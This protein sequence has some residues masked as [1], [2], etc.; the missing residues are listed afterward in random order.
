VSFRVFRATSAGVVGLCILLGG[1]SALAAT[2]AARPRGVN[3]RTGRATPPFSELVKAARKNDR[4]ALERLA[5]RFGVARL[6]E[7]ARGA[8]GAVARA[9]LEAI[10]FARG[11]VL[12]AGTVADRLDAGDPLLA[13]AA[14]RALGALLDGDAPTELAEWEVPADVVARACGGLRALATRA[15]AAAAARLEALDALAAAQVTCPPSADLAALLRD[16]S[17]AVRRSA[18][19][20]LATLPAGE[21]R[22]AALGLG[23]ADPDPGVS[24]A[25]AAAVCRRVEPSR[26]RRASGDAL[27]EQATGAARALVAI[28]ATRPE[29][30]VEMLA[31]VAAAGTPADRALLEKLR[32]GAASPVRDRAVELLAVAAPGKPGAPE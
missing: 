4:A 16:P 24:A 17:P 20:L 6:G 11:G 8:D 12:L 2:K 27:V 1:A 15:D 21:A 26:A 31:C 13:I 29:D 25:C 22:A 9:A 32:A 18:G 23:M 19:L 10:P 3:A 30:A 7:G 5:G 14:A 28:P